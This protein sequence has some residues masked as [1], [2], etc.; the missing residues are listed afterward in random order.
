MFVNPQ[1]LFYQEIVWKI[2]LVLVYWEILFFWSVH[3]NTGFWKMHRSAY[4]VQKYSWKTNIRYGFGL[5]HTNTYKRKHPVVESQQTYGLTD[6]TTFSIIAHIYL[7]P[8]Q[9]LVAC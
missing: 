2:L 5:Q 7:Q 9:R 4:W 6:K 3:M 8:H 1:V